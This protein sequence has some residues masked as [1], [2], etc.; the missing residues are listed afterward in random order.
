MADKEKKS[1][2]KADAAA[3]KPVKKKQKGHRV[4]RFFHDLKSEVKKV[5]WPKPRAV[6]KN[7]GVVVAMIA[8]VGLAVFGLDAAFTHLL[9]LFMDVAV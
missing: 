3:G 8:V 9:A 5:V 2:T 6:W 4:R 7:V 1:V